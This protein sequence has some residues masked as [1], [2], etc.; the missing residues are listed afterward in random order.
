MF[1]SAT[2]VS[3]RIIRSKKFKM[4][5]RGALFSA[6]VIGQYPTNRFSTSC[7]ATLTKQPL[8]SQPDVDI[9]LEKET[10]HIIEKTK[11]VI[12]RIQKLL[13]YAQRLFLYAL[14]GVPVVLIGSTAYASGGVAP[15]IEDV[16]W[17]SCLWAIQLLGP[18]F[19]KL[20]QWASTRPDLYPPALIKRLESLQD[21][22]KVDYSIESVERTLR[23]AFGDDWT[24]LRIEPK[25]VGAGCVAQ[26]FKGSLIDKKTK[27]KQDVA[28]KLIHPH[29]EKMIKTDMEL[30]ALFASFID[31]YFLLFDYFA[32]FITIGII[33]LIP[34]DNRVIT[35]FQQ[36]SFSPDSKYR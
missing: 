30:L 9:I 24:D 22:V 11:V 31:R 17:D 19:M 12:R 8:N 4:M 5:A 34:V 27:K 18:T 6:L 36:D 23:L 3:H 33:I 10:S 21:H 25:P 2:R 7:D 32:I 29:V 16:I 28:I 20:A 35:I 26:V 15:V 1:A 14:L 13:E